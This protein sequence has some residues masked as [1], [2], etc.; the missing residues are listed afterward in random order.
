M[1]RY[2]TTRVVFDVDGTLINFDD[3]PRFFIIKMLI[4]MHTLG[5]IIDVHSGGGED[6]AMQ[7]V[8]KLGLTEYVND[9][10]CKGP[11]LE[12]PG[13]DIAFDD[14]H[15]KYGKVNIKV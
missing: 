15:V 11:T 7:W 10:F 12:K 2:V 5:C 8:R 3:T 1:D 4:D 6:Y 13:Y 14:E 9:I